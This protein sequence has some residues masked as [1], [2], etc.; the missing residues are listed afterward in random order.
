M[1]L[2]LVADLR[3]RS[4]LDAASTANLQNLMTDEL[5]GLVK[6]LETGPDTWTSRGPDLIPEISK[7][8]IIHS[9][10][11]ADISHLG[12]EAKVLASGRHVLFTN[13]GELECWDVEEDRLV[14][15]HLPAFKKAQV[16][17]FAAEEAE[18]GD[19]LTILICERTIR[20]GGRDS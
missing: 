17:K 1:W 19:A 12:N 2:V 6:R 11:Q 10:I 7:E 20:S 14:W 3:H 18:G 4:I 9:E 15:K 8:M 5:V 13:A 16:Y